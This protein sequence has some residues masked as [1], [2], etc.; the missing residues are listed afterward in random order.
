VT[1]KVT[2]EMEVYSS[3]WTDASV[4]AQG[5]VNSGSVVT[6]NV[7]RHPDTNMC[8]IRFNVGPYIHDYTHEWEGPTTWFYNVSNA[9]DNGFYKLERVNIKL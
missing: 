8:A 5:H 1:N 9:D 4:L 3:R 7:F 6:K 2:A